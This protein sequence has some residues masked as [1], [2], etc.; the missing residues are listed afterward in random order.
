MVWNQ[1]CNISKIR[2]CVCVCVCVCTQ[3]YT[4]YFQ[5]FYPAIIDA[6][7]PHSGYLWDTKKITTIQESTAHAANTTFNTR[8]PTFISVTLQDREGF[9]LNPSWTLEGEMPGE[10]HGRN[11]IAVLLGRYLLWCRIPAAAAQAPLFTWLGRECNGNTIN[12]MV[13]KE[14]ISNLN[15]T[16]VVKWVWAGLW[17]GKE[18]MHRITLVF[19]FLVFFF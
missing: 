15:Y 17:N 4:K 16:Q 6:I 9:A 11:E 3:I 19:F 14:V 10:F 12:L 7:H 8:G 13:L 18:S 5:R 2:L 1:T